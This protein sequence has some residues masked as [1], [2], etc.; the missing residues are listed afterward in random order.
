MADVTR[1]I[2]LRHLRSDTS[3]HVLHYKGEKLVRSGRGVSFWFLPLS[4]SVAE[5]PVDDREV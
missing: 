1:V 2:F 5:I 4:S 3:S